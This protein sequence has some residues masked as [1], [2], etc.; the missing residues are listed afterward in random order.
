MR[1]IGPNKE[2]LGPIL[3]G[4]VFWGYIFEPKLIFY[5]KN[6]DNKFL[7]WMRSFHPEGST[8]HALSKDFSRDYNASIFRVNQSGYLSQIAWLQKAL[9]SINAPDITSKSP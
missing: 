2:F 5:P 3:Y 1:E 8:V 4:T 6:G 9:I 7:L